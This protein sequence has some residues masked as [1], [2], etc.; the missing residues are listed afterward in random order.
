MCL[1][2]HNFIYCLIGFVCICL[3]SC[4]TDRDEVWA[5]GRKIIMPSQTGKGITMLYSD[6]AE[7]KIRLEAEEM[8]IFEKDVKEKIT[9]LPKGLFV[10]FFD[11][12][13]K[14][15]TTLKADYGVKYETSKKMDVKRNVV[16][17]NKDGETLNTEH[18]VWD[19][20][21]NKIY[22]DTFVKITTGKEI[23]TGKGLV[24]NQDF[25]QYEIKEIT[26]TVSLNE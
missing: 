14:P 22:S 20:N 1:F 26:G 11:S 17:V 18:L 23:I 7:I 13:G 19:E 16:V 2:K 3:S 15:S 21:T 6:S 4:K 9:I 8:Q 12:Q 24:A 5:I 10:T 25:T